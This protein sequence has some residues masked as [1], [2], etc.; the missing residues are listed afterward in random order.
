MLETNLELPESLISLLRL[1]LSPDDEWEKARDKGKPPKPKIDERVLTLILSVLRR[2]LEE[3][4]TSLEVG[5]LSPSA[6]G[7]FVDFCD[8]V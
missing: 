2:R 3:Y 8:L 7:S 6:S 5:Y 1:L 4:P